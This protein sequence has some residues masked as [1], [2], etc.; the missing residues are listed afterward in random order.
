VETE[1]V[2]NTEVIMKSITR[3]VGSLGI[4]T[5]A[6]NAL[7]ASEAAG[8]SGADPQQDRVR[9]GL[10]LGVGSVGVAGRVGL[11]I[12]TSEN[13]FLTFRL[14]SVEELAI[15]GPLPAER[16]WDLGVL[17][18]TQRRSRR[19]FASAAV[20]LALVGGVRRGERLPRSMTCT[21][22]L[23]LLGALFTP[24]RHEELPFNTVGIP[25][26]LEAGFALTS[27]LGVNASTW[28]NLNPERSMAG[29][30]VGLMVGRL[31]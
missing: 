18:G 23:C 21:D 7:G 8:Q 11:T 2:S 1:P 27:K 4:V 29:L 17:Y 30:S 3:V 5:L 15:L 9:V 16:V 28:A 26:E 31:R 14:A 25:L 12:D 20:G 22:F 10:G 6:M 13:R 24:T 19:T